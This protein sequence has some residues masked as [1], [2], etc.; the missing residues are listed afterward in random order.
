MI[1]Y[2]NGGFGVGKTTVARLLVT[3]LQPA[4]LFDP[5]LVGGILRDTLSG[6]DPRDDF[7]EYPAWAALVKTFLAELRRRYP[8]VTIVVPMSVLDEDKR[9]DVVKRIRDVDREFFNFTLV[10]DRDELRRR[11]LER[12]L[13]TSSREWCLRHLHDAPT[14]SL[15]ES[16]VIDTTRL[17]PR[18]VAASILATIRKGRA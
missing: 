6:I 11:V 13:K 12:P 4:V 17:T 1:V 14:S 7:Q 15:E 16:Y 3:E 8:A 18:E 9:A 5:E 2:L 10:A